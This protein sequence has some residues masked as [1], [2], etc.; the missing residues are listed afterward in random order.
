VRAV[1]GRSSSPR[2]CTTRAPRAEKALV[3]LNCAAIPENLLESELFGHERGSF[4][5]AV[6]KKLGQ[7]ELADQGTIFLDEIGSSRRRCRRSSAVIEQ[8]EYLRSG[9]KHE[10]PSVD[11]RIIAG[12]RTAISTA[13][14]CGFL[15]GRTFYYRLNVVSLHLPAALRDRPEDLPC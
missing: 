4:T 1:P 14:R 9:G 11:V 2:R 8:G 13:T 6:Q 12:R 3:T 5:D 7:F 15:V 10:H